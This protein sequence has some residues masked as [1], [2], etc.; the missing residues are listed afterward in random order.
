VVGWRPN[1]PCWRRNGSTVTDY[2]K[3][4]LFVQE[5]SRHLTW[6]L[7]DGHSIDCSS[8]LCGLNSL[9]RCIQAVQPDRPLHSIPPVTSFCCSKSTTSECLYARTECS[10]K[11]SLNS[12]LISRA[13]IVSETSLDETQSLLQPANEA[14]LTPTKRSL[15]PMLTYPLITIAIIAT[16]LVCWFIQKAV[17]NT[18]PDHGTLNPKFEWKSQFLGYLSAALYLGSRVPQIAHN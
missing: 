11:S 3:H 10:R 2:G 17:E 6:H 5:C 16:G 13:T 14:T 8:D 12:T 7:S 18:Q 1:E 4:S 9:C 15:S